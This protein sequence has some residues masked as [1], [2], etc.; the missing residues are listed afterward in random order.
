MVHER[1]GVARGGQGPRAARVLAVV[2]DRAERQHRAAREAGP[3]AR[4][5]D[6]VGKVAGDRLTLR[7]ARAEDDRDADGAARTVAIGMEHSNARTVPE[8][9]AATEQLDQ[10]F[11]VLAHVGPRKRLLPQREA[12]G[13]ARPDG[14]VDAARCKVTQRRDRGGGHHRMSKRGDRHAGAE[15][16]GGGAARALGERHPDVGIERG[17]VVEPRSPEAER[18]G[19]R[20][21]IGGRHGRGERA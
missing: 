1:A 17:R 19:V 7:P 6:A 4:R 14:E 15:L 16:D 10:G 13:E 2:E 3:R 20:D 21:V 11:D 8:R 18:F 12:T 5:K 9:S